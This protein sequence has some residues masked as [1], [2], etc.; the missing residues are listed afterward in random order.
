M[1]DLFDALLAFVWWKH[2]NDA[3]TAQATKTEREIAQAKNQR[4]PQAWAAVVGEWL[5]R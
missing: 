2:D 4:S 1:G 3:Q 5:S